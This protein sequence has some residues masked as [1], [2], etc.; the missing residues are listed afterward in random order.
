[1]LHRAVELGGFFGTTYATEN[2]YEIW[3]MEH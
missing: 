2:G 3:N 1:M